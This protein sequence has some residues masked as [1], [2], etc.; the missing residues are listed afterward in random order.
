[1]ADT[2]NHRIQKFTANGK[3]IAMWGEPGLAETENKFWGPRGIAVDRI[4]NVFVTD[5]GNNRVVVFDGNGGF[6]TQF[7]INGIGSGEFDEPVGIAVDDAGKIYVADTWNQRIQVFEPTASGTYQFLKEW[8]I[9]GWY[10]QSVNNK[11]FLALDADANVYVTDPDGYRVLEFDDQGDLIRNWGQYSSGIDGFGS[12]SGIAV[13]SDGKVWIS[14]A[15]NN[16]ALRF[17]LPTTVPILPGLPELPL[18]PEGLHYNADNG[19]IDNALNRSVY[20]LNSEKN[21]WQPV[22]PD[23]IAGLLQSNAQPSRDE[24]NNWVLTSPDG[25]PVFRWDPMLLLWIS[26]NPAS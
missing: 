3:F 22:V 26:T 17:T 11:P 13:D 2:W 10:G 25:S 4:G 1:V 15:E 7:G 6:I 20:Q 8:Q 16:F 24:E 14:D 12:P 9:S 18:G 5:T 23:E 21:E 19:M